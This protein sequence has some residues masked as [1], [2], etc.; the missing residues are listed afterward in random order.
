MSISLLPGSWGHLNVL[1]PRVLSVLW[2]QAVFTPFSSHSLWLPLYGLELPLVC[3][4]PF[5]ACTPGGT[6]RAG[7]L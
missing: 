2:L 3:H 4:L 6:Q 5:S 7:G 1:H